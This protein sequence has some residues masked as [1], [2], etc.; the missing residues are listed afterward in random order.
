MEFILN[1]LATVQRNL[2]MFSNLADLATS[3]NERILLIV[4]AA[5]VEILSNF[6]KECGLFELEEVDKYLYG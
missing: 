1:Q 2:I 5:H 6:I 4:G 3:P